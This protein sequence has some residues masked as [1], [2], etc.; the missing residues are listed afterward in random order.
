MLVRSGSMSMS[1]FLFTDL[2]AAEGEDER[3]ALEAVGFAELVDEVLLV[4]FEHELG[5]VDKEKKWVQR[6]LAQGSR[7]EAS[8]WTG[9]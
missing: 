6:R 7:Y 8:S 5:F 2:L 3:N 4:G 1:I 9:G